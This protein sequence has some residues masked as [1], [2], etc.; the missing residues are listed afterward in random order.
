MHE[1]YDQSGQAVRPVAA[2]VCFDHVTAASNP[3]RPTKVSQR[4]DKLQLVVA[5]LAR[6]LELRCSFCDMACHLMS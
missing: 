2:V 6:W 5:G 3:P 1:E 4:L